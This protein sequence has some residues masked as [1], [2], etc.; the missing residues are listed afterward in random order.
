[1]GGCLVLWKTP[2][3]ARISQSSCEAEVK[4]TNECVENAQIFRH[5]L[6]D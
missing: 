1:M 6:S 5:I 3:D 4:P 2:N